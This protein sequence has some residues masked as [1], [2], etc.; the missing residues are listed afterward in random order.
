MLV[1]RHFVPQVRYINNLQI[2]FKDKYTVVVSQ[3]KLCVLLHRW[4]KKSYP[5][6]HSFCRCL[7][8]RNNIRSVYEIIALATKYDVES[9]TVTTTIRSL[10]PKGIK[11]LPERYQHG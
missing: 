11:V 9:H 6:W 2:Y 5:R 4:C 7:Q 8:R 3:G 1:K 10:P